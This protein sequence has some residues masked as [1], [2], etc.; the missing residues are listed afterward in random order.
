MFSAG[1]QLFEVELL[2]KAPGRG[3]RAPVRSEEVIR[4]A[5]HF[6]GGGTSFEEP[7]TR[8]VEAVAQES[9]RRGDIVFITDGEAHVSDAFLADLAKK[10]KKHRFSIRGIVVDVAHSRTETLE[11]FCDDVR[12]VTD[13]TA[14]SMKDLFAAV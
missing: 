3:G 11:R 5:E 8:A 6:P 14:D 4:F 9:Y 13:L 12:A 10:K 7:L 1:H 2:G